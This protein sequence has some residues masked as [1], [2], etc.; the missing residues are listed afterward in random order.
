MD[1]TKNYTIINKPSQKST[2]NKD[3]LKI[4][5]K[6]LEL[7]TETEMHGKQ[8]IKH[9]NELD[10]NQI[11]TELNIDKC[12]FLGYTII[13]NENTDILDNE[14][15]SITEALYLSCLIVKHHQNTKNSY[16]L[17]EVYNDPKNSHIIYNII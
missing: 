17:A 16:R 10:I 14:V 11:K 13:K 2:I 12:E 9:L 3:F 6:C 8:I 4:V 1:R 7:M 15:L 5:R